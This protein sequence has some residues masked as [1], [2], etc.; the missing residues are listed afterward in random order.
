MVALTVL[1]TFTNPMNFDWTQRIT[2]GLALLF[3]AYFFAHTVHRTNQLKNATPIAQSVPTPVPTSPLQPEKKLISTVG[4]PHGD[5]EEPKAEPAP[6]PT[7]STKPRAPNDSVKG[8]IKTMKDEI[9]KVP[10]GGVVSIN[11]RGGITAGQIN[12]TGPPPVKVDFVEV[13]LN[14]PE[15][16]PEGKVY[17]TSIRILLSGFVPRLIVAV[18]A[19]SLIDV[20]LLSD[21]GSTLGAAWPTKDGTGKQAIDNVNGSCMLYLRSKTPEYFKVEYICQG[22]QCVGP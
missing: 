17:K 19:P 2:G 14:A 9:P 5:R 13:S 3:A 11:Q 21:S 22:V 4:L 16:R 12:I 20:A 8:N 18:S 10:P 6:P 7:P 15:D 1:I